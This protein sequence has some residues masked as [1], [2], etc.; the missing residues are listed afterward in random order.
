MDEAENIRHWEANAE[1]WTRLSRQGYDVYRDFL[2]S[3]CFFGTL[4]PVDGLSGLDVGCGEGTNTRAAARLGARMTAIDVA[5]TF[6]RHARESEAAES[7][8]IN[9]VEASGTS[10]PFADESFDFVM[11]TMSFMDIPEPDLALAEAF[12]VSRPGAFLQFSITHPC[13]YTRKFAW[14]RDESGRKTGIVVGDYFHRSNG[15][16]VE[17]W[18]FGAAPPE[19]RDRFPK[20]RI[21]LFTRTLSEW[22]NAVIDAGFTIQ[23]I[24]EPRPSGEALVRHPELHGALIFPLFLHIR[25]GKPA[26]SG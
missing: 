3:P 16:W 19:E 8:G 13:F 24:D 23:R 2:N 5:P 12:R 11:A 4:P 17:E 6:L 1:A 26:I 14:V 15:D 25:A 10:L 9:Y 21:P 22:L 18:C 7:L 20:F